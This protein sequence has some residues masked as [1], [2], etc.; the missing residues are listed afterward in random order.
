MS[1]VPCSTATQA[2]SR[3]RC[4]LGNSSALGGGQCLGARGEADDHVV[5]L[6]A[7]VSSESDD[8]RRKTINTLSRI[9]KRRGATAFKR[10]TQYR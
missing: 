7:P 9:T 5:A 3:V 4:W 2:P 1:A 10:R 8:R 6:R